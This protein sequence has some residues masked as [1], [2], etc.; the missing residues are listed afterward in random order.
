[1]E[2]REKQRKL[3]EM[4]KA[5]ARKKRDYAHQKRVLQ[6]AE[7]ARGRANHTEEAAMKTKRGPHRSNLLAQARTAGMSPKKE[8]VQRD[9][10]QVSLLSA[11]HIG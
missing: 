4:K 9:Y 6:R 10:A 8:E 1:M 5:A 11:N 3:A 2:E 7:E